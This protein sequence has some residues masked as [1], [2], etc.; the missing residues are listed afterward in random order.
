MLGLS[1]GITNIDSAICKIPYYDFV[2]KT[3]FAA[4]KDFNTR[5]AVKI[6]RLI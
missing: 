4:S 1:I 6:R 2:L 5:W 3:E